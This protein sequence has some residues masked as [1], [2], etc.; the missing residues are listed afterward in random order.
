MRN[1]WAIAL[2]L[3]CFTTSLVGTSVSAV[4]QTDGV[5]FFEAKIRPVL[6]QHC[7][8]CHSAEAQ[9]RKTWKGGLLLDSREGIRTGGKTGPAVVPGDVGASL[10]LDALRQKDFAMPPTGKLPDTVIA[11]FERW[12][13]N[14]AADPRD[15]K[16]T[17][18]EG[19]DLERGRQFWSFQPLK[20][21]Q[22][23]AVKDEAWSRSDVDRFILASLESA[24]LHPVADA[25]PYTLVRRVYFDLIG[26]PP[27]AEELSTFVQQYTAYSHLHDSPSSTTGV[28]ALSREEGGKTY[29]ILIDK[30]LASP[31][32]GERWGRHWLDVA[33]YAESTGQ[34]PIG[35]YRHAWRYR[36]YV[37]DAFNGDKPY[38]LFVREQ[39]AGDLLKSDML[40]QR[41][42][43][44]VA[45]GFLAIGPRNLAENNPLQYVMEN[46]NEQI[47]TIGQ[48][49]LGM[50]IGCARC[51][52]HKFDPI[53]AVDYYALAGILR[54]SELMIGP[55][56]ARGY[57]G[58]PS[59][60]LSLEM[61]E[62][63]PQFAAYQAFMQQEVALTGQIESAVEEIGRIEP[64]FAS[65]VAKAG[66]VRNL[67]VANL[68]ALVASR[69]PGGV[70]RALSP[71][72]E[73]KRD[74]LIVKGLAI[75]EELNE[76]KRRKQEAAVDGQ[77]YRD[78]QQRENELTPRLEKIKADYYALTKSAT[79]PT[80]RMVKQTKSAP[81]GDE[82][83][84]ASRAEELKAK[85]STL[86]D[87]LEKLRRANP[88]PVAMGVKEAEQPQDSPLYTRGNIESPGPT[89]PRDSCK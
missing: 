63:D 18:D 17:L 7:Y 51:H 88:A 83:T 20:R 67:S 19:I 87:D 35:I 55:A 9:A 21:S 34:T 85:L 82:T 3:G 32:F 39:V 65:A 1:H 60:L 80:V 11:D 38:D 53:P 52:D 6:A 73:K 13:R 72:A 27:T 46:V 61:R 57:F 77:E 79:T 56:A 15:G 4:E 49:F 64:Q 5:A 54:S 70:N 33:R 74:D 81:E 76:V 69:S 45:T 25:D 28:E 40:E 31:Q 12:V 24:G 89:V 10:L 30:L 66:G 86:V 75:F 29:E 8:R 59:Q 84:A 37:I 14:G 42:E 26:L 43:R 44:L 36:D 68:R 16:A 50:S 71:E 22:P 47:E 58:K 2:L 62:T 23:P 78:L 48:A 41:N